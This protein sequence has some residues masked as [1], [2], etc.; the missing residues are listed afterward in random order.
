MGDTLNWLLRAALGLALFFGCMY[1]IYQTVSI[2]GVA[3]N[4]ILAVSA[5]VFIGLLGLGLLFGTYILC[6]LFSVDES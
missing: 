4:P 6:K 3:E 1:G 5:G 2:K